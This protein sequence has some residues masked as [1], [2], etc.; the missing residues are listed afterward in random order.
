MFYNIPCLSPIVFLKLIQGC[1]PLVNHINRFVQILRVDMIE[2]SKIIRVVC[3]STQWF[4]RIV[5]IG[6][7]QNFEKEWNCIDSESRHTS[8]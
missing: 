2:I 5:A 7:G 3:V 6:I 8:L 1:T 4:I